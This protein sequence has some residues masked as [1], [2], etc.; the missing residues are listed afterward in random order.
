MLEN[1]L[2]TSSGALSFTAGHVDEVHVDERQHCCESGTLPPMKSLKLAAD[3][4]ACHL[5]YLPHVFLRFLPPASHNSHFSH[6]FTR[7]SE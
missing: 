2:P 4:Q 5:R 6:F 3:A 1:P 7:H